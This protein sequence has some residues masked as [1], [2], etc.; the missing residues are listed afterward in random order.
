M[1]LI[2]NQLIPKLY[3]QY[4]LYFSLVYV[5]V[6]AEHTELHIIVFKMPAG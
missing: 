1:K 4:L 2:I 3:S 6:S 5:L